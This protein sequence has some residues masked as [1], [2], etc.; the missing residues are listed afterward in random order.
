MNNLLA[1]IE[2]RAIDPNLGSGISEGSEGSG[3]IL[4]RMIV[5]VWS[6]L[7]TLGGLAVIVFFIVGAL[8]W[9]TA[10]GDP[11][12][13]EA[14]RNTIINALIGMTILFAA[15]AF[16]NFIGPAL[17]FDLLALEFL[18]PEDFN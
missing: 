17:G 6:T 5:L 13:V 14:A 15:I 11:Q 7:L 3:Q 8:R 10:G 16:A 12:R 1:Q 4:A 9:L 18:T 2:N